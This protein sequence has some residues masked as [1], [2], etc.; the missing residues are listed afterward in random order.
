MIDERLRHRASTRE[1][2]DDAPDMRDW[3]W[4]GAPP[5]GEA[6]TDAQRAQRD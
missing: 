6:A 5:P 3:M 2:R 1:T 4:P